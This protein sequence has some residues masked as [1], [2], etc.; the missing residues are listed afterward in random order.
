MHLWQRSCDSSIKQTQVIC[1]SNAVTS[2]A[3]ELASVH[4][5]NMNSSVSFCQDPTLSN[6]S[7][8]SSDQVDVVDGKVNTSDQNKTPD[9]T[10]YNAPEAKPK[11]NKDKRLPTLTFEA[12]AAE[13]ELDMLLGS[14][15]ETKL[16][17]S[18]S[19]RPS[20]QQEAPIAVP[21]HS[22]KSMT[23]AISS[24]N[25][26]DDLDNLLEETSSLVKQKALFSSNEAMPIHNMQ[27]SSIRASA[28]PPQGRKGSDLFE[29][30]SSNANLDD[31]LDFLLEETSNS[32]KQDNFSQ[33]NQ[34]NA[35]S[36]SKPKVLAD[37]DSWLDT[38]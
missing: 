17:D 12:T 9:S 2:E 23:P 14:F 24:I 18:S 25:L 16:L 30:K 29:S 7:L 5:K 32:G 33:P 28:G 6:P 15:S 20:A 26:D 31:A 37:F 21:Q 19:I 35:S 22:S 38:I 10:R 34:M 11:Q 4:N 3:E 8:I 27:S 36:S 13:A 1:K